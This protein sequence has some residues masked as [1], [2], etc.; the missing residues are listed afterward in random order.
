MAALLTSWP[1]K[2]CTCVST[3]C[4]GS[5][6]GQ[7]C[8]PAGGKAENTLAANSRAQLCCAR[9]TRGTQDVTEAVPCS[10]SNYLLLLLLFSVETINDGQFHS[11][12]LVMLN[13]TLNLVVDKGAPKS[14]GKLQKQSSVSLNTPLYIGG[15]VSCSRI[16]VLTCFLR[17]KSSSMLWG[18]LS[19]SHYRNSLLG[20]SAAPRTAW[21]QAVRAEVEV[22]VGV[23]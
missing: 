5:A 21:H 14:L 2:R 10:S 4:P 17:S 19:H 22:P 1:L 11:V 13:Q 9:C 15:T 8:L 6:E 18:G 3:A 16:E 12:E 7:L 20:I 23:P